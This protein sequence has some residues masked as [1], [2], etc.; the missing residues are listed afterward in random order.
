MLA[1]LEAVHLLLAFP[2]FVC[3]VAVD[4][5]WVERCLRAKHQQLF[6]DEE[7]QTAAPRDEQAAP[8]TVADYLE[9]IFQIPIWMAPIE[10]RQRATLVKALLGPSAAPVA[11]KEQKRDEHH[12]GNG[13]PRQPREEAPRGN[14]FVQLVERA[15][16]T[17][18]PLRITEEEAEFV[19]EIKALLSDRPRA[20]KR[21]VNVYRLLKA[22]LSDLDRSRFVTAE[23]SSPHRICIGQ[24]ALFTSR[25]RLAPLFIRELVRARGQGK[26]LAQW[27]EGLTEG[28]QAMLRAPFAL[29]PDCEVVTVDQFCL[30]LPDTSRYLFHRA[31]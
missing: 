1:V 25:P 16:E 21:F 5:R 13:A 22:S 7:Q 6:A 3:A 12:N 18:D 4:P 8:V 10:E 27:F 23:R 19:H 11:P 24:L 30:W 14:A 26:T 20:L 9:K 2:L 17:Q 29:L 31:Q 15:R 28:D